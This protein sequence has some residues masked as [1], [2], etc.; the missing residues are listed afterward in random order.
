MTASFANTP[1]ETTIPIVFDSN[2]SQGTGAVSAGI[3]LRGSDHA[4]LSASRIGGSPGTDLKYDT[5]RDPAS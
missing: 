4:S 3:G 1:Y 5:D 2:S